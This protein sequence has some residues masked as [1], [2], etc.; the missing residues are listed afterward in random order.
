[1]KIILLFSVLPVWAGFANLRRKRF[2]QHHRGVSRVN[3]TRIGDITG[4]QQ[5]NQQL[6][7]YEDGT[8]INQQRSSSDEHSINQLSTEQLTKM[9]TQRTVQ[10]T[11]RNIFPH[12]FMKKGRHV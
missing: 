3:P 4:M 10:K 5:I 6:E 12:F 1:M 2:F 9:L 8:N 7:S 11:I